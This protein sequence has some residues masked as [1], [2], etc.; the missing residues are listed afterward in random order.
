MDMITLNDHHSEVLHEYNVSLNRIAYEATR[1]DNAKSF[2]EMRKLLDTIINYSDEFY[3]GVSEDGALDEW[4]FMYPNMTYYAMAG[5]L[6]AKRGMYEDGYI[7]VLES[8]LMS[9]A[10][11]VI[12]EL[13]DIL[14]TISEEVEKDLCGLKKQEK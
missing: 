1:N 11:E 14:K 3:K 10:T 2:L 4:I 6:L 9:D 7:E 13:S 5:F 12:G 8:E